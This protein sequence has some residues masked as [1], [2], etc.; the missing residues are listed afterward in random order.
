MNDLLNN[1]KKHYKK[2]LLSCL[3]IILVDAVFLSLMSGKFNSMILSI[4]GSKIK[5]NYVSAI[6]CYILM[7]VGYNY[8]I[9]FQ[10]KGLIDSFILGIVIYGIYETTNKAIIK[11]WK[12]DVV[13]ID[14]L[15][16]GTLFTITT[17]ILSLLKL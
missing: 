17:F 14:T 16:G 8:F 3:I 2:I 5:I 11:N 15:W 12:W 13:L 10:N 9:T 1:I 4:Q 6:I 7:I